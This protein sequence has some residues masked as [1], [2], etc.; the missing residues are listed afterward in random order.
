MENKKGQEMSVSTL[1]LIVLGVVILVILV[2]GFSLGWDTIFGKLKFVP[3]DLQALKSACPTYSEQNLVIDYCQLR[4]IKTSV[5]GK[6][7]YLNCEDP[8]V[9]STSSIQC[10]KDP[11]A[12]STIKG[13]CESLV[14]SG[15]LD[16]TIINGQDG[17]TFCGPY[18]A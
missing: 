16:K 1:I 5:I 14:N 8:R 13:F 9:K 12:K 18:T 15:K 6:K 11:N 3:S 2:L 10:D 17:G 4:E 7:E